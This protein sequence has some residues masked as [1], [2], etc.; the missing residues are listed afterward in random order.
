MKVISF[1]LPNCQI[2]VRID[3]GRKITS[4]VNAYRSS[5]AI[6]GLMAHGAQSYCDSL[7]LFYNTLLLLYW[8]LILI[9]QQSCAYQEYATNIA[10]HYFRSLN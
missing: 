3:I 2:I 4:T 8:L 7:I 1:H 5:I 6:I 9:K 10:I